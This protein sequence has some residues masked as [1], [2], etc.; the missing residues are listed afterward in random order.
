MLPPTQVG[1]E[2]QPLC[3]A[4]LRAGEHQPGGGGEGGVGPDG[5]AAV[6]GAGEEG[7][8]APLPQVDGGAGVAL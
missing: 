4:L 2:E 3:G 1:K 5:P 8:K 6:A 7:G